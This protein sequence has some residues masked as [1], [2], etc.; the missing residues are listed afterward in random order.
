MAMMM[1]KTSK[2]H[3]SVR[4]APGSDLISSPRTVAEEAAN[5]VAEARS[6]I[7]TMPIPKFLATT[8]QAYK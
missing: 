8:L 3:R 5:T 1:M 2:I 7:G 4:P 6:V